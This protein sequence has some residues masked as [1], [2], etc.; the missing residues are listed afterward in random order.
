MGTLVNISSTM[1]LLACLAAAASASP[2]VHIINGQE[3]DSIED[4]PHQVSL[5]PASGSHMCGGSIVTNKHVVT[6]AHC[7]YT[8]RNLRVLVG[9]KDRTAGTQYMVTSFVNFPEY[10]SSDFDNDV[11]VVTI[12]D[13][14]SWGTTVSPINF[15]TMLQVG[16]LPLLNNDYCNEVIWTSEN[17]DF[18]TRNMVCAGAEGEDAEG[19][20][21][22]MGDSGGPL[23]VEIDGDR[24]LL[25]AV[26]F[27][28]RFCS[29]NYAGVYTNL[30]TSKMQSW[31][32]D[33]ISN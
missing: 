7:Y 21:S 22:C 8:P 2:I 1:K 32:N 31:V 17:S 18:I 12:T 23:T 9:S 27:G 13:T 25:G 16:D 26:S 14:F 28:H 15:P 29:P 3:I 20:S 11:A 4:A 5:K 10:V 19:V 6:A 33:Q 30:S 24:R